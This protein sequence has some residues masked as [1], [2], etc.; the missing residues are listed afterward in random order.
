MRPACCWLDMPDLEVS[1]PLQYFPPSLGE[2]YLHRWQWVLYASGVTQKVLRRTSL[3]IDVA[4]RRQ[5]EASSPLAATARYLECGCQRCCLVLFIT[6][7]GIMML[8]CPG[9]KPPQMIFFG[10]VK[11]RGVSFC[12][13]PFTENSRVCNPLPTE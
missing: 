10:A 12:P 5:N 7:K 3:T 9:D 13:L 6:E 2:A 11:V 4:Y 8:L 1:L